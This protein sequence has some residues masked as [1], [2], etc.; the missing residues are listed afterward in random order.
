MATKDVCLDHDH[1]SGVIRAALCRN[2]NGI[3]G[4]VYNL[5]NRAKRGATP[6]RW[7]A[8]VV[9]YW[10]SHNTPKEGDVYH[11]NHKTE[12]EK[13]LAR[14]KKARLKRAKAKA[15]ANIKGK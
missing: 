3:E 2:C 12:D 14:N 9:R 5:A 10:V 7:L 13:R 6:E 1:K 11:P 4:K 8:N 15:T